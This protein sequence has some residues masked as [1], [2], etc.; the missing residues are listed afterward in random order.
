LWAH[1]MAFVGLS[2]GGRRE[3]SRRRG[4][5]RGIS[6]ERNKLPD[7]GEEGGYRPG[8]RGD[9]GSGRVI[10]ELNQYTKVIEHRGEESFN[11]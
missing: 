1:G 8:L 7:G 3:H 9:I 4:V 2:L 5:N 11:V 10:G 6:R